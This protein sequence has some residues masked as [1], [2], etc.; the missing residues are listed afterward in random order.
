MAKKKNRAQVN[1]DPITD[2]ETVRRL[3]GENRLTVGAVNARLSARVLRETILKWMKCGL[4]P[5][6]RA[7]SARVL[8]ESY[9][10]GQELITSVEALERF[11]ARIS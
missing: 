6:R 5:R 9:P 4:L 8:L 7:G 1:H 2:Q 3:M 11:F 10:E